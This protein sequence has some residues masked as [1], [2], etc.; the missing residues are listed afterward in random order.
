MRPPPMGNCP[1]QHVSIRNL[2]YR[3]TPIRVDLRLPC[4]SRL[5]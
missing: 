3:Q 1:H 5:P 2:A 4:L